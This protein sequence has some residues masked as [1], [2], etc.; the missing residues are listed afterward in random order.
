MNNNKNNEKIDISF[1][2]LT[3]LT[4]SSSN[5]LIDLSSNIIPYIPSNGD[6]IECIL[7]KGFNTKI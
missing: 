1:N 6:K 2:D 7:Q 5:N 4:D 3:E